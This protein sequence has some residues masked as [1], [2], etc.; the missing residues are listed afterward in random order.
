MLGL[1]LAATMGLLVMAALYDNF[2]D[3]IQVGAGTGDMLLYYTTL[4]PSYLSIV[5][6]LSM[7]L[8]LLFVLS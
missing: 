3:L 6:P 5:L 4:M 1:L 8:S 7:L 2:R